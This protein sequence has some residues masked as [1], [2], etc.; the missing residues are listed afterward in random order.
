MRT[1]IQRYCKK[2]D[3]AHSFRLNNYPI[4]YLTY[5]KYVEAEDPLHAL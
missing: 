3:M 2:S 5:K 4:F 1:A